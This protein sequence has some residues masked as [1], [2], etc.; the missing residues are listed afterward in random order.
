MKK[1]FLC[2]LLAAITITSYCQSINE[3]ISKNEVTRIETILAA[4][5]MMGR[6]SFSAGSE[7]AA[8]FIAAEFKKIG[9]Q[10]FEGV[11]GYKQNFSMVKPKFKSLT[12][13]F[14]DKNLDNKSVIVVTSQQELRVT[15][16]SGYKKVY[17]KAGT[18]F[19]KK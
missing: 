11:Q 8:D 10:Q 4:D 16:Q 12:A 3:I 2:L 19:L 6:K 14:D 15:G 13:T 1:I 5:D 9:L 17:V 7:K 18:D